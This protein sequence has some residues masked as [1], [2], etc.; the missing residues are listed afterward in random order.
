MADYWTEAIAEERRDMV[1]SLLIAGGLIYDLERG[2]IV[3]LIP[4]PSMLPVLTLGLE[5]TGHWEQRE[6]GLWMREECLLPKQVREKLHVAPPQMPC[7]KIQQ[8]EEA[9][10]LVQKG[11]PIRQVSR[12]L[13]I[14]YESIRRR[15]KIRRCAQQRQ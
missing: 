5:E 14:S 1:W 15:L 4:R 10:D 6:S 12:E 7:L 3:G 2:A 11:V 8:Q 13:G 9:L